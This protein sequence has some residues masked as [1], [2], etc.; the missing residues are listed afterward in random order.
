MNNYNKPVYTLLK[1]NAIVAELG[2]AIGGHAKEIL[3]FNKP[4]KLFLIDSW[5]PVDKNYKYPIHR[6]KSLEIIIKN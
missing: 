2:V 6:H 5:T 3:D 4:E 1:K